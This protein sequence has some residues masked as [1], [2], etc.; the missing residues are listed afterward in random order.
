MGKKIWYGLLVLVLVFG[1]TVVGCD[2][3][4]TDNDGKRITITGISGITGDVSIFLYREWN[5]EASAAG[6]GIISNN[7]VT[8]TLINKY[9]KQW[10]GRGSFF[11]MLHIDEFCDIHECTYLFTNGQTWTQLGIDENSNWNQVYASL[12]KYNITSNTSIIAFNNFQKELHWDNEWEIDYDWTPPSN[13]TQLTVNQWRDGNITNYNNMDW[14]SISVT[15]GQTYYIWWNDD[16]DGD[17]TKTGDICVT[18]GYSTGG[19]FIFENVD[20]GWNNP[21]SFTANI[22]GR[23]YIRITPYYNTGTYSLVYSTDSIRPI[24]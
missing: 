1:M 24:R 15:V 11:I 18:A 5:E 2:D 12:P 23:V 21:R 3:S 9:Y 7:S 13:P 10:N 16:Y 8:T 4:S 22:T 6:R 20:S 17:N 14:Y 19:T